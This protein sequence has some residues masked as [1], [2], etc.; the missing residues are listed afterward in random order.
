MRQNIRAY[1]ETGSMI[2]YLYGNNDTKPI[3]WK[4]ATI[5]HYS[6]RS[7]AEV[8]WVSED[9]MK[10]QIQKYKVKRVDKRGCCENQEYLYDELEPHVTELVWRPR[11]QK[12]VKI[13]NEIDLKP[14][15]RKEF[16][17]KTKNLAD[18][19]WQ[20]VWEEYYGSVMKEVMIEGF[21]DLQ[22]KMVLVEGKTYLKKCSAPV[23]IIFG[24]KDEYY[25]FSF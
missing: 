7:A 24:I 15:Y 8:I 19:E 17:S 5:L 4:G 21:N 2:N 14:T 3:A 12:W 9:G 20:K 11:T 16:E 10:C 22:K 25:D 18:K 1:I 13:W 6:D 23:N